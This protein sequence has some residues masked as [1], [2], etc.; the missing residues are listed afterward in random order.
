[1]VKQYCILLVDD[2][3]KEAGRWLLP[4]QA[5]GLLREI[6]LNSIFVNFS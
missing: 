6:S 2:N 4:Q 1:M 3:G 5:G